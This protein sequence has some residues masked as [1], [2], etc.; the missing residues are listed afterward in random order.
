[1]NLLSDR[2]SVAGAA[3]LAIVAA[4]ALATAIAGVFTMP[5]LDRDEARFAQ[6]TAQML[7]TGDYV[8]IRFQED[9]RNKKPAGIHWLQAASVAALSSVEAREIW[10]YRIPS[11]GGA[12]LA[13]LFTYLA[14]ARLF[15]PAAGFLGALLLAS[16]PAVAGEATIAKTDAVL[17]ACVTGAQAAFI[18]IFA[19][20]AEGRRVSGALPLAFWIAIGAGVLIK[21]PIILLV[22]GLN[23]AWMFF[24]RPKTGWIAALRPVTGLIILTLMIAPWAFAV[25]EATDGRF[26]VDAVGGDMLA[27][28]GGAQESH[29]GPPGYH[30]VL[31]FALF[32]PAAALVVPGLRATFSAR[33]QWQNRFLFGWAAPSWIVLELTA[34]KLPHYA[35][36]LYPALALVVANFAVAGA[37]DLWPGLRRAGAALYIAIGLLFSAV[38]AALPMFY[39]E[40]ALRAYCLAAAAALG[41]ASIAAGALFFFSRAIEGAITAALVSSALAWTLL[42]GV[43]PN[44]DR[45]A[46]SPRLSAAIDA[47]GLHALRDGADPTILSG[48]YEPSAIFL[49]GTRTSLA[50]GRSAAE[51]FAGAE[52]AAVVETRE[53]RAFLDRLSSLGVGAEK[54]AEIE[55]FNYSNGKDVALSIYRHAPAISARNSL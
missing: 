48:Y 13:A 49:L 38:V 18:C 19:N 31:L 17:L 12:L 47:A 20:V 21:G 15:S 35:L 40:G 7:E 24:F 5:P 52:G 29:G 8:S 22:V 53:E 33:S 51:R 6:A 36:P 26:F 44:L 39:Q 2:T 25:N 27:K 23:A 10:A 32:W 46:L 3:R 43:L 55:G 16:A 11:V 28:L 42:A 34:T 37:S 30:A 50:D 1:M 14:G 9:E 54:F 45:L 41:G 4:F